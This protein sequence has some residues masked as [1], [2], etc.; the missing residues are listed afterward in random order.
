MA[1]GKFREGL[2]ELGNGAYAYLQPDGSWG[3]SNAG[4]IVSIAA[5]R[6]WSTR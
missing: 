5:R 3:L 6:C 4:L 2:H 1:K